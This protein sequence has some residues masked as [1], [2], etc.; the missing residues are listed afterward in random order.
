[1]AWPV[2]LTMMVV[3][4]G[5]LAT[6]VYAVSRI[7]Q[8]RVPARTQDNSLVAH[9]LGVDPSASTPSPVSV[10]QRS[11]VRPA[12][13]SM[14]GAAIGF[15][16][17]PFAAILALMALDLV[18]PDDG[19]PFSPSIMMCSVLPSA[20]LLV[21]AA[22]APQRWRPLLIGLALGSLVV[23]LLIAV[24]ILVVGFAFEGI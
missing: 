11:S 17:G 16:G 12:A 2:V 6:A 7:V 23:C 4:G 13:F 8:Q 21:L 10:A 15:A 18:D 20:I 1:V 5:L 3:G 14:I 9:I 24:P 22:L 19:I